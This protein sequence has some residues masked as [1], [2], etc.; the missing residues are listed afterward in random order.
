VKRSVVVGV[1]VFAM[2]ALPVGARADQAKNIAESAGAAVLTTIFCSSVALT[3]SEEID[4]DDFARRGFFV[5]VE[6]SYA[7][8]TFE[9]DAN[10]DLDKVLGTSADLSVDNSLGVNGRVGYRC[11]SRFSAEAQFEW[12]GGFDSDFSTM[13]GAPYGKMKYEPFVAT[14]N[15]RGYLLTGR[16]QPFLL[17]GA[18]MM[19][20][21][22]NLRSE[23]VGIGLSRNQSDSG[24]AM[25][26]GGGIDLYATK[27]FVVSLETD[28][29]KP[30]GNVDTFHYVSIGWGVQYRF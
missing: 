7:A 3:S 2:L 10:Q 27:N 12:L 13:G 20:V 23:S 5:G 4:P 18:G 9:S 25:R 11:H 28:Y 21:N 14:T 17:V 6:G 15:V 1:T 29:V 8:E 30:F 19:T 22:Q 16:Y 26:F 24:F